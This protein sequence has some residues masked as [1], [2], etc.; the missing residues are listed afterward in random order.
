MKLIKRRAMSI[1]GQRSIALFTVVVAGIG[2]PCILNVDEAEESVTCT[3][4]L[5]GLPDVLSI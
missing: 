5:T 1:R 3:D 4:K 2:L